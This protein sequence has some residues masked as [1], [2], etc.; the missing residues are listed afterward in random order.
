MD[1]MNKIP[2][3]ENN[4]KLKEQETPA[5]EHVEVGEPIVNVPAPKAPIPKLPLIIG[6]AVAGIAA[7]AIAIGVILGGGNGNQG[8]GNTPGGDGHEHSYSEWAVVDYPTCTEA[9]GEERVCECGEKETRPLSAFGHIEEI[10]PAV[11]STCTEN[12]LTEGKKCSVCGEILIAQDEAP[13]KAHT[14]EIIPAVE[15]TCTETG[16]TEGKKCSVCDSTLVSQQETPFVHHTYDD[17]YDESCNE[18]GSIREAECAHT[19]TQTIKGYN[20]TCISSGLTDGKQCTTCNEIIQAQSVIAT[21]GHTP[22]EWFV[23]EEPSKDSEGIRYQFCEMCD[24]FLTDETIPATEHNFGEKIFVPTTTICTGDYFIRVCRECGYI[25]YSR[26]VSNDIHPH[27]FEGE[28]TTPTCTTDGRV[29]VTCKNCGIVGA[30]E[31]YNAWGHDIRYEISSQTHKAICKRVNCGYAG[32][33]EA[34][35]YSDGS[36]CFGTTCSVCD[37]VLAEGEGHIIPTNYEADETHHWKICQREGCGKT[38]ERATHTSGGSRC[39]DESAICSVCNT[40]YRPSGKHSWGNRTIITKPTCTTSGKYQIEC[41]WC[42]KIEENTIAR[43]EHSVKIWTVESNHDCTNSGLKS[44]HCV[45]CNLELEEKIA[46]LGHRW[47]DYGNDETSHWR[48]CNRCNATQEPESHYGGSSTCIFKGKCTACGYAYLDMLEHEY[49]FDYD[50]EYHFYICTNGCNNKTDIEKHTIIYYAET[51]S[52]SDDGAQILYNHTIYSKCEKCNSKHVEDE[53]IGSEHYGVKILGYVHPTCTE[54]GLTW[55]WRCAVPECGDVFNPQEV[56]PALGHNYVGG[57]CTRCGESMAPGLYDQNNV[58]VASWEKLT[59]D[60]GMDITKDYT[61]DSYKTTLSS[62]YYILNNNAELAVGVHLIIGNNTTNIGNKAFYSCSKLASVVIGESVENIGGSAFEYCGSLSSVVIG[63][64]VK[65]IGSSAFSDCS[66]LSSIVIPDSVT[67][68]GSWVFS[69]CSSLSS[70]VIGNSVTTI[71]SCAFWGCSSLSSI[72]IPD[73]VT[74]IDFTPF[75]YC[76]SLT[77]IDVNPD[78]A[79]YTSIDG[80]LYTKDGTTLLQY[81]IGKTD[82]TFIIPDGVTTIGGDAFLA[83]RIISSI[84]IPDSVTTIGGNAFASCNSLSSIVIPDSVTI[85]GSYAFE[86]CWSLSSIIIP[87]SVTRIGSYAF[88][89]CSKL[90]SVVIPDSVTSI[91]NSAFS[92]CHS[93]LYTEYE[94][95]KYVRSGD[96]PYAVL[97]ET[98]NQNMSSYVI[99]EDTRI[100]AGFAFSGC[101]RLSSITIPDGVTSIS[102]HALINCN[103]LTSVV[104]GNSVTSIGDYAFCG[105]NSLTSVVIGDSV[106]SIDNKA[107]S[108]CTSLTSVVIPDSVKSIGNSAFSNCT[109]LTSVV[110]GNSVTSIDDEAFS[111]CTSL[112]SVVI[113]DSVKSIGNYAFYY[114]KSLTSIMIPDSVTSIGNYAFYYCTSLTSVVIGDSVTSISDYAFCGCSSLTSVVIGDSVTSIGNSAFFWC[115]SLTSVVIGDSVTSIGNSAFSCCYSLTNIYFEGNIEQWKAITKGEKWK[116]VVPATIVICSDGTVSIK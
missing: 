42:G 116:Y 90:T 52:K 115:D 50:D 21:I 30:D 32:N 22:S 64:G 65:S 14:E 92:Y 102:S 58:L 109:S 51:V 91:G 71:G 79:K 63:N 100:I 16:L 86:Y 54:D 105:C 87:D 13:L 73:S 72:V 31:S 77:N 11:E 23:V 49:K 99:H 61:S 81:A 85:I 60:Y 78:N 95:G 75:L 10:I 104:I 94:Y 26:D 20:A 98:T 59:N 108:N 1:E 97:I 8:G 74:S 18:C 43:L 48:V 27:D 83:C 36:P 84:V 38:L 15:S 4:E 24:T 45:F 67:S 62:P 29:I 3:M 35:V 110:I 6:G 82:T 40:E 113:P 33:A 103:S 2:E 69:N 101:S 111:N 80:N 19:E 47:S 56:I 70:V 7:I 39:I 106:T 12:G 41:L 112:T 46:A 37:Y 9:G 57:I 25:D 55:G 93:S 89:H 66:S 28:I 88:S 34:H 5:P 76:G 107:F 96:N 114:C 44:G 68:I 17:E 53:I